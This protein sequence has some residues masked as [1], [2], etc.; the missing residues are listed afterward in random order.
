MRISK[1]YLLTTVSFKRSK[2][3]RNQTINFLEGENHG[4]LRTTL[5]TGDVKRAS[6]R[7]VL[8]VEWKTEYWKQ[9]VKKVMLFSHE[10]TLDRHYVT[11][12]FVLDRKVL[13]D[14]YR[15]SG[16]SVFE[17]W[18]TRGLMRRL[19]IESFPDI[20]YLVKATNEAMQFEDS[21]ERVTRLLTNSKPLM[22]VT[23]RKD[24]YLMMPEG[25]LFCD[26]CLVVVPAE[27]NKSSKGLVREASDLLLEYE[28][29]AGNDISKKV[30]R[31][32]YYLDYIEAIPIFNGIDNVAHLRVLLCTKHNGGQNEIT[33][34]DSIV[35][36]H[37]FDIALQVLEY[38]SNDLRKL[39]ASRSDLDSYVNSISDG[40]AFRNYSDRFKH[41]RLEYIQAKFEC[42][43]LLQ[44]YRS[45]TKQEF[46][47]IFKEHLSA[48]EIKHLSDSS[49]PYSWSV[50]GRKLNKFDSLMT[51]IERQ[52]TDMSEKDRYINEQVR[53]I[54][55]IESSN[56][57]LRLQ[58]TLKRLTWL[59]IALGLLTLF[60]SLYGSE[61]K[62]WI[63]GVFGLGSNAG[64]GNISG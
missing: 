63:N 27:V 61:V 8:S 58:K 31:P 30:L 7:P 36:L 6:Q 50:M 9:H 62:E 44:K 19:A 59:A 45:N 11:L 2:N 15:L 35:K 43:S 64:K 14:L 39:Y 26:M 17:E 51:E 56:I 3:F 12:L 38:M 5:F 4:W 54:I 48:L 21:A 33:I 52:I 29:W 40:D 34:P 1:L 28:N 49:S 23:Y 55:S 42:E 46:P 25:F 10:V 24:H 41:E 53:D 18:S 16:K 37:E 13:K 32:Y 57:N 22:K 47:Y 20:E 60:V